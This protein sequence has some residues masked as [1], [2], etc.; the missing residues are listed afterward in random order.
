MPAAASASIASWPRGSTWQPRTATAWS[1]WFAGSFERTVPRASGSGGPK[2]VLNGI[3]PT[4]VTGKTTHPGHF[5]DQ[6]RG[7]AGSGGIFD[8]CIAKSDE[9][10]FGVD[11]EPRGQHVCAQ[12]VPARA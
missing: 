5:A 3:L 9:I 12:A 10:V 4:R 6:R 8:E 2:R 1:D 11:I 7:P